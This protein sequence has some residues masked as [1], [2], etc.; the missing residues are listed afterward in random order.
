[1]W[2]IGGVILKRKDRNRQRGT[3][4]TGSL[5]TIQPKY[6]GWHRI[7]SFT[8]GVQQLTTCATAKPNIMCEVG[9]LHILLGCTICPVDLATF[10]PNSRIY[11]IY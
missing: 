10:A 5:S 7:P 2:T 9:A 3:G 6:S 11:I 1:M 8:V 4:I